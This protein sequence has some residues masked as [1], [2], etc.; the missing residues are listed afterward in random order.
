MCVSSWLTREHPRATTLA[1]TAAACTPPRAHHS[2]RYWNSIRFTGRQSSD[3][4]RV[5]G[6]VQRELVEKLVDNLGD[7]LVDLLAEYDPAI[8]HP[9]VY[10]LSSTCHR[11]FGFTRYASQVINANKSE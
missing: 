4:H 11:R 9:I 3:H 6:L 5:S 2:G 8:F 1:H 7:K 10:Y